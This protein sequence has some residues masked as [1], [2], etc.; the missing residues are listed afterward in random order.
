M[1]E[2]QF[3]F[4]FIHGL[5]L[6]VNLLKLNVIVLESRSDS[7]RLLFKKVDYQFL[8]LLTFSE[9]NMELDKSWLSSV[10]KPRLPSR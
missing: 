4:V 5:F 3:L 7:L 1:D 8:P 6:S 10:P 2:D 9:G